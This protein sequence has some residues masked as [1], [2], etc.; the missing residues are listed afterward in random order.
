MLVT[1]EFR[2]AG[3]RRKRALER[4]PCT[5]ETQN[6]VRRQG[7]TNFFLPSVPRCSSLDSKAAHRGSRH[8]RDALI[9]LRIITVVSSSPSTHGP[10]DCA[11]L[12]WP[13]PRTIC[14]SHF[15][16]SIRS[17]RIAVDDLAASLPSCDWHAPSK[18]FEAGCN[19][20]CVMYGTVS[21][22]VSC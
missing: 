8:R 11:M 12:T 16:I 13:K 18:N 19:Y 1:P 21:R 7:I 2:C 3:G 10:A 15:L 5:Q 20:C 14:V 22:C 6:W 17:L 9:S 4:G